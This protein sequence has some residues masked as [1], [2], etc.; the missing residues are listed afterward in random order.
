M[1]RG[2]NY[3]IGLSGSGQVVAD[4]GRIT[5][6]LGGITSVWS[7]LTL[8]A[9]GGGITATIAGLHSAFV[10]LRSIIAAVPGPWKIV[11]W[12]VAAVAGAVA[13]KMVPAWME[14]RRQAKELEAALKD[15]EEALAE[16][17]RATPW[18]KVVAESLRRVTDGFDSLRAKVEGLNDAFAEGEK[19]MAEGAGRRAAELA[20][21]GIEAETARRLREEGGTPEA[22][23]RIEFEGRREAIVAEGEARR[24]AAR[25]EQAQLAQRRRDREE[26]LQLQDELVQRL[27]EEQGG[28]EAM[29]GLRNTQL[30]ELEA[31]QGTT[32]E[33]RAV[34]ARAVPGKVKEILEARA[35]LEAANAALRDAQKAATD[36]RNKAEGEQIVEDHRWSQLDQEQG[37]ALTV[38]DVRLR[39]N[40]ERYRR[41]KDDLAKAAAERDTKEPKPS[42]WEDVSA[43]EMMRSMGEAEDDGEYRPGSHFRRSYAWGGKVGLHGLTPGRLGRHDIRKHYADLQQSVLGEKNEVSLDSKATKTLEKI[44]QNTREGVK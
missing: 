36:L 32:D 1:E 43:H 23:A 3:K 24:R 5:R 17:N 27:T 38:T 28:A 25:D 30:A 41:Q 4:A 2:L 33:G 7:G 19:M 21:A 9:S 20:Q 31:N 6:A 15:V 18:S 26:E 11:A 37:Q 16:L 42:R 29:L 14:A 22:D 12:V 40:E 39:T 13:Y 8:A 35:A 34:V 10:G 44:E